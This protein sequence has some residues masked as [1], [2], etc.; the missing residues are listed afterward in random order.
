MRNFSL[1]LLSAGFK[2]RF[3][4]TM[5]EKKVYRIDEGSTEDVS[6]KS[7]HDIINVSNGNKT[8]HEDGHNN[9]MKVT[10]GENNSTIEN[11]S[12]PATDSSTPL[13]GTRQIQALLLFSCFFVS[14]YMRAS[15]SMAIVVMTSKNNT[16]GGYEVYNW[17]EPEKGTVLSSF[18]VGYFLM[19]PFA[20]QLG[21]RYSSKLLLGLSLFEGSILCLITPFVIPIGGWKA[22]CGLRILLGLN[23][24]FLTP[25]CYTLAAKWSPPNERNRFVGFSVNGATLG[26][27]L[28]MPMAG[29]L[30][31][32]S[33]GWP[34]VFY[35]AG[36]LGFLWNL[37]WHFYGADSPASHPKISKKERDFIINS[38]GDDVDDSKN[39]ETPWKAIF[40]SLPVW[41]LICAHL[42]NGW[43]FGILTTQLPSFISAALGFNIQEN[44][45]LSALP[46]LSM[47]VLTF[48][49]CWMGDVLI[50]KEILTKTVSRKLWT[51]IALSG[52]P[53]IFII[54]TCV[55]NNPTIVMALMVTAATCFIFIFIGFNINHLDLTPNFAGV[56][57]GICNGFEMIT[58]TISPTTVGFMVSDPSS[59]E[60]WRRVFVV[61][62]V[63]GMTSSLIYAVFGSGK[64]QPWNEPSK[65]KNKIPLHIKQASS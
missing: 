15:L 21:L 8:I 64:I 1:N 41:A 63:I 50:S 54:M 44:G 32:S 6:Q 42:G 27:C 58:T 40:T 16:N 36:L 9:N 7:N 11:K 47:W 22:L 20:G 3:F 51:A 57:M 10:N 60:L 43:A 39:L 23:Q 19:L 33:F 26:L 12:V 31:G 28:A 35:S 59:I 56:L 38:L 49:L 48:P 62:A 4:P 17:T 34:S 61:T 55:G 25:I 18:Y 5:E 14:F 45:L 13:L 65:S 30:A 52:G 2:H 37:F 29:Y 24:G 46:F 53:L